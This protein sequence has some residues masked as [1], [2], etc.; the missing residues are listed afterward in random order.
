MLIVSTNQ[1]FSVAC[2]VQPWL[3]SVL[4]KCMSKT[5]QHLLNVLYC[6]NYTNILWHDV[7]C[8]D[9]KNQQNT[10]MDYCKGYSPV[11]PCV[12]DFWNWYKHAYQ[13]YPFSS[14]F[15]WINQNFRVM[16]VCYYMR[17][18]S[19][20]QGHLN[21]SRQIQGLEHKLLC[22]ERTWWCNHGPH[23]PT[24]YLVPTGFHCMACYPT[25]CLMFML[26]HYAC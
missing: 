25:I 16:Q 4:S 2:I 21:K 20:W 8:Y 13:I 15:Q 14:L 12:F 3:G 18:I 26:N 9:S 11:K 17:E 24:S 10:L 6:C 5:V 23:S 22:R 19:L 1:W 7:V